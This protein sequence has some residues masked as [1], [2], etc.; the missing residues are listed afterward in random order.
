MLS[1]LSGLYPKHSRNTTTVSFFLWSLLQYLPNCTHPWVLPGL[2]L[3]RLYPMVAAQPPAAGPLLPEAG[4]D[5]LLPP[6]AGSA[7]NQQ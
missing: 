4:C 3:K 1:M 5:N 7:V 6:E 2:S